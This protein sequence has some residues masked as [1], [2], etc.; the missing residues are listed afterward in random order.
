MTGVEKLIEKAGSPR[1]VA[2]RL[3]AEGHTC[4]R[5][6]V[7]YWVGKKYVTPTWAQRV[8]KIY[9]IPLHELNPTVYPRPN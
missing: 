7:E 8:N 2:E 4:T 6:L 9:E 5:Q 1:A 3:T